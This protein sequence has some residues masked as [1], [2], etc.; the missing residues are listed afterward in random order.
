M[1]GPDPKN[2]SRLRKPHLCLQDGRARLGAHHRGRAR[3][4][5]E[6][7]EIAKTTLGEL[8][9]RYRNEVVVHKRARDTETR[10]IDRLLRDPVST[11]SLAS[12]D[13]T[14]LAAFR[15]RR[16]RDGVRTCRYDLVLIRHALHLART[17]W[18]YALPLNPVD[19]I[20][21]PPLPASRERRLDQGEFAALRAA[22]SRGTNPWIWPMAELAQLH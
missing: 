8:L 15:D 9:T 14:V 22:S 21:K 20:R 11:V 4:G 5:G 13:A 19:G 18:G 17:E 7:R 16:T 12:L 1:A 6:A 3:K 10:R 2:G